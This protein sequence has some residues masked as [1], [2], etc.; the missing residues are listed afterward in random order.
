M[1]VRVFAATNRDID[2]EAAQGTF[3]A[4]LLH[5]LDVARTQGEGFEA[6][7]ALGLQAMLVSPHFVFRVELD[8]TP[9]ATAPHA[10]NDHELAARLWNYCEHATGLPWP[11]LNDAGA[12]SMLQTLRTAAG[13]RTSS[14]PA[15]SLVLPVPGDVRGLPAG[16]TFARD[17]VAAGEAIVVQTPGGGGHGRT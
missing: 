7:V 9:T 6:G 13:P 5:R 2:A 11:D 3:R 1:R 8:P 12:V 16:T 14:G 10:L 4:D 17:A 15:L